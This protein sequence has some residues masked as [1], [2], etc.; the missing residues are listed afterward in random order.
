MAEQAAE[1]QDP[2][3]LKLANEALARLDAPAPVKLY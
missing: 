2:P 3:A 1:L